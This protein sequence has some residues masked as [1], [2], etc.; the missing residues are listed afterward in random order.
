MVRLQPAAL[1]ETSRRLDDFL[2]SALMDAM[3]NMK[4]IQ[5]SEIAKQ[6][7][8][9]AAEKFCTDFEHVEHKLTLA[10][11]LASPD[12]GVGHELIGGGSE[13]LRVLFPRTTG[14]IRVLLS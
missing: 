1:I 14:E 10:D 8:E 3:E 6:I 2:P 11:E 9:D 12:H 7:T 5:D 13:G 4:W